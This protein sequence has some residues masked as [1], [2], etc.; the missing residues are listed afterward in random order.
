MN[1]N[2]VRETKT[3]VQMK[4]RTTKKKNKVIVKKKQIQKEET[5]K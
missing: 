1:T 3:K 4:K 2:K 5:Y